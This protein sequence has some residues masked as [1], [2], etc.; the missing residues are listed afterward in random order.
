MR[1]WDIATASQ[2]AETLMHTGSVR[3][4]SFN[5]DEQQIFSHDSDGAVRV[6]IMDGTLER[7]MQ[8]SDEGVRLAAGRRNQSRFSAKSRAMRKR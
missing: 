6:W 5:A 8:F 3:S 7:R 4:M 2:S 1:I